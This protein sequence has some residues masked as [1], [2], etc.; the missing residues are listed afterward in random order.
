MQNPYATPRTQQSHEAPLWQTIFY[1]FYWPAWWIGTAL[2]IGSWLGIVSPTIGWIGFSVAAVAAFG[3]Y[4]LPRFAGVKEEEWALLT[5]RML[6]THDNGYRIAME[7]FQ[8]G[9][10]LMYDGVGFAL[11]PNNE[12]ACATVASVPVDELNNTIAFADATNAKALF[13]TLVHRSPEFASAVAGRVFR[14]S[15]LSDFGA[16]GVEV[17]RVVGDSVDW[18]SQ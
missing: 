7:R 1:R 5:T 10:S 2:I 15:I 12:I 18:E 4:V 6:D 16:T 11:R 8:N 14:V 3:S 9:G 17:C 13:E